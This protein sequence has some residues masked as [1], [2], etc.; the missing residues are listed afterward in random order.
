M[1]ALDG[2][3]IKM[4]DFSVHL[5]KDKYLDTHEYMD[6][7]SFNANLSAMRFPQDYPVLNHPSTILCIK[8]NTQALQAEFEF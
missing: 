8:G 1:S 5:L 3:W 4:G 6:Q 2:K 7:G